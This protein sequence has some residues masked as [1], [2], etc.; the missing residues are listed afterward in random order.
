MIG[1]SAIYDQIGGI[2]LENYINQFVYIRK[3]VG[4]DYVWFGTDFDSL[5]D[6]DIIFLKNFEDVSKFGNVIKKL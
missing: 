5:I 6:P 2:K 4:V 3:L 1:I